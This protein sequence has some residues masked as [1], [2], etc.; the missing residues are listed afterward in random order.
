MVAAF[1]ENKQSVQGFLEPRLGPRTMSLLLH[2][3]EWS[4]PWGQ[5]KFK[6]WG[7]RFFL[8]VEGDAQS[9]CKG[10]EAWK[11]VENWDHFP[12][13]SITLGFC[14]WLFRYSP[15]INLTHV[16]VFPSSHSPWCQHILS[17]IK[18]N[19]SSVKLKTV[20][21]SSPSVDWKSPSSAWHN[22]VKGFWM[23]CSSRD[24]CLSTQTNPSLLY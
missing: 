19:F 9:Q 13:I 6:D 22:L 15:P 8:L 5:S 17:S 1:H 7:N 20:L 11:G 24:C 10:L 21:L 4:K 2:F 12:K 16:M 3:T 14:L 18:F 23:R